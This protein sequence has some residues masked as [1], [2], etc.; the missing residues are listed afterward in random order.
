MKRKL[1]SFVL[2]FCFMGVVSANTIFWGQTGHRVVGEIAQKHLT[3][4]AKKNLIKLLGKEGLAM[5]STYGDDIKSDRSFDKFKPWHYINFNDDETIET[6]TPNAKGD[7]VRGI[8]ICIK[9]IK[10]E[11]TPKEEKVMYL[12]LLVHFIG[13]LHQPLHIGRPGDK[14]GNDLKVKWFWKDSNLH[15]VWDSGMINSFGMTYSELSDNLDVFSANQIKEVQK[16]TV[17]DWMKDTRKMTKQVYQSA[18]N[19]D[20]LN[21]RY[22][23]LHFDKVK[24]QLQKGG[25]RL[26]KV[27]NDIFG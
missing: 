9:K 4:K 12:K 24:R 16:G 23:Y 19:G 22:M 18:K 1:F 27:I 3:K 5:V 26:A 7:I 15:R 20:S 2:S 10:A 8:E 14:G 11:S 17:V 25:Y 21:Y 13:D 6:A